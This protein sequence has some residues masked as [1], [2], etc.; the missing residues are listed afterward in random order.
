MKCR[1]GLTYQAH[2]GVQDDSLAMAQGRGGLREGGTEPEATNLNSDA[3]NDLESAH[4]ERTTDKGPRDRDRDLEYPSGTEPSRSANNSSRAPQNGWQ[5]TK[6]HE[7]SLQRARTQL[8]R[9]RSYHSQDFDIRDSDLDV[10]AYAGHSCKDHTTREDVAWIIAVLIGVSFGT[11]GF[12]TEICIEALEQAKEN[13]IERAIEAEGHDLL[14]LAMLVALA[15]AAVYSVVPSSLCAFVEPVAGGS[16]VAEVKLFLNGIWIE[17][18]LTLKTLI[19]KMA[20]VVPTIASG[21]IAGV[22]GPFVHGGA[23]L[24]SLLARAG[25]MGMR[26]RSIGNF[27]SDEVHKDF[28]AIGSAVGVATAFGSP[29][30]GLLFA[31]EESISHHSIKTLWKSFLATSTAVFTTKFLLTI[32]EE[33]ESSPGHKLGLRRF[34]G[35]YPDD[36]AVYARSYYY[37]YW[38]MPLFIVM[39]LFAAVLGAFFVFLNSRVAS[40]RRRVIGSISW[41]QVVEIVVIIML[42]NVAFM[43]IAFYSRCKERPTQQ[44][45]DDYEGSLFRRFWCNEDEYSQ[46]ASFALSPLKKATQAVLHLGQRSESELDVFPESLALLGGVSFIFMALMYGSTIPHGIFVPSIFIGAVFGRLGAIGVR[47]IMSSQ[48][49]ASADLPSEHTWSTIGAASS[50]AAI[51]RMNLS[52]AVIIM[53]TTGSLQLIIPITLAVFVAKFSSDR[54][55][56]GVEDKHIRKRGAP[57]LEEPYQSIENTAAGEKALLSELMTPARDFNALPT[58][59][60]VRDVLHMLHTCQH[61]SFP[62][63]PDGQG[64]STTGEQAVVLLGLIKYKHLR[65]MLW[66]RIGYFEDGGAPPGLPSEH[67]RL[68]EVRSELDALADNVSLENIERSLTTDERERYRIDLEPYMQ[69]HPHMLPGD[70]PLTRAYKMFRTLGLHHIVVT[71]PDPLVLGIMTR[72]DLMKENVQLKLAKAGFTID[73]VSK[74]GSKFTYKHRDTYLNH[75]IDLHSALASATALHECETNNGQTDPPYRRENGDQ[76]HQQAEALR[77]NEGGQDEPREQPVLLRRYSGF[78]ANENKGNSSES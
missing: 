5:H 7:K 53:E 65:R 13:S 42:T 67:S 50:M 76:Q 27:R 39:G 58:R 36:I 46:V 16:G 30:G 29:V 23:A 66:Y 28:V 48:G 43:L 10:E 47:S 1:M 63:T 37:F 77:D 3:L 49:L 40:L 55:C 11:L 14:R 57:I 26:G 75:R 12:L 71:A 21:I 35:L 72:F 6:Q 56:P 33:A 70:V 38:E 31:I 20:G 59:P 18:L 44:I 32:Y 22:E 17:R 74:D 2:V 52:V 15:F 64:A 19:I 24:G 45:E 61:E 25:S 4:I 60:R 69:R 68:E 8:A 51:T 34:F 73:G 62:V 54:I 78:S 41:R 9:M